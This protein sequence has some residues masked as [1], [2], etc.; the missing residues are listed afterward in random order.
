MTLRSR[1]FALE[2]RTTLVELVALQTA[3]VVRWSA[4]ALS[5]EDSRENLKGWLDDISASLDRAFGERLRDPAL[6]A[7]YADEIKE[8]VEDMK[9]QIDKFAEDAARLR[10]AQG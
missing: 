5:I 4:L 9:K 8:I 3:L 7:L 1:P 6:S 10:D 2:F